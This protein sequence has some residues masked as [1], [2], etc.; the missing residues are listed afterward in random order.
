MI[1][2]KQVEVPA[3]TKTEEAGVV[4]DLC[5]MEYRN[6]RTNKSGL[7]VSWNEVSGGDDVETAIYMNRSRGGE[8]GGETTENC[9]HICPKCC[10]IYLLPWLAQ[11][12]ANINTQTYDW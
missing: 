2:T 5:K 9:V 10:E 12:G 11:Q 7:E 8:D 3:T 4:C 1:K 6:A